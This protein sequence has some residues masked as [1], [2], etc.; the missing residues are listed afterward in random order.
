MF[1]SEMGKCMLRQQVCIACEIV[2][3]F[4]PAV[5]IVSSSD[6]KCG[7]IVDQLLFNE[8]LHERL[9]IHFLDKKVQ[10]SSHRRSPHTASI[11]ERVLLG[12]WSQP[13]VK[14][15]LPAMA[16]PCT[17]TNI[18]RKDPGQGDKYNSSRFAVPFLQALRM[19]LLCLT[20]SEMLRA[21]SGSNC[22]HTLSA[23]LHGCIASTQL[24]S[25]VL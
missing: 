6:P 5:P 15:E 10:S 23:R 13:D 17:G 2:Q 14:A 1:S 3:R 25:G 11:D 9:H 4:I 19:L 22:A 16:T 21:L 8:I 12:R 20:S 7:P 18:D 24:Y